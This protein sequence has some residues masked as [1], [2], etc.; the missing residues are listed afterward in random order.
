MKAHRLSAAALLSS[1]VEILI[2]ALLSGQLARKGPGPSPAEVRSWK[3]SLPALAR[4]LTDAG[5]D[6]V[7]MLIEYQLPNTSKRA[8]VVLAGRHP[9]TGADSFVVIELK[10][11]SKAAPVDHDGR[12]VAVSGMRSPQLHPILQVGAYGDYMRDHLGIFD[13]RDAELSGVAYLHNAS[14]QDVAGLRALPPSDSGRLFTGDEKDA[15]IA[16][17]RSRLAPDNA[18]GAGDRFLTAQVRPSKRLMAVAAEEIRRREQFVLLDE[19][20]VAYLTVR[21]AWMR[22]KRS[23][24]KEVVVVTGGPGSGKSVIAL[25]LLGELFRRGVSAYHATGSKSFTQTLRTV[26]SKGAPAVRELFKYFNQF[27][28]AQKNDIEVLICDEAHRLRENSVNRYTSKHLRENARSQLEELID[29]ARVPVFLLDEHQVVKSGEMGSV[30]QITDFA[31]SRGLKVHVVDL[32]GQFRNGGSRVYEDWVLALLGLRGDTPT[33]WHGDERFHLSVA[34][35]P[36]ELEEFLAARLVEG[37][38][39]RM[40]AGFCWK[41]SN[42]AADGTLIPDVVVGD[43][44]RPWNVKN[45]RAVGDAP[46]SPLW[47]T[48]P[49]GFGQVGC[50]YTAQGFEYDWNGVILGPDIVV[51]DGVLTTVRAHNADPEVGRKKGLPEDEADRLIRNT[52][53]VLLTRAMR[54]TVLYSVDPETN[55]FL[56]TLVG[57]SAA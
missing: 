31:T 24:T 7:E 32:D 48:H 28:S 36:A 17:L 3:A 5:L 43:W 45:D 11:W 52:Y 41:W 27:M 22:A 21:D 50:V 54:G 29:A 55:A 57:P 16:H 38:T 51:R 19:Q 10:Q 46:P 34:D 44:A 47:A 12:L 8:D 2:E 18:T 14:E 4:D 35:S 33:R 49:G 15:L 1:P 56:K 37:E 9:V 20:Q 40:T 39:A 6:K 53:K 26:P 23:D 30:A 13:G 42:P 25:S